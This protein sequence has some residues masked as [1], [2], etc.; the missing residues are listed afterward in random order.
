MLGMV[1]GFALL[2]GCLAAEPAT[3]SPD[4]PVA[5]AQSEIGADASAGVAANTN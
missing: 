4:V 5:A 2:T 1:A 3:L